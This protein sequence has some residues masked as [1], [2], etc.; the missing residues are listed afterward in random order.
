MA[1]SNRTTV[2]NLVNHH[3]VTPL[4]DDKTKKWLAQW[5]SDNGY[6]RAYGSNPNNWS[7]LIN[8]FTGKRSYAQAHLVGQRV[9]SRT[10][11]ASAAE[12]KAGYRLIPIVKDIWGQI[13]WGAGN[14]TINKGAIN[15]EHCGDYRNYT[16]R[17]KDCEVIADFWR[18]Q[19]KKLKGNTRVWGHKE[20]SQT[21]TACPARI[22]EK[23][24]L[25]V[26]Y[27]NNPPKEEDEMISAH[28]LNVL[29]RLYKGGSP[30]AAQKKLYVGKVSFDRMSQ[31]IQKGTHYKSIVAKAKAGK[32]DPSVHLPSAIRNVYKPPVAQPPKSTE[33]KPGI[34]EVK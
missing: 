13:V 1:D 18:P 20:V 2:K 4:W 29:F 17:S 11:D 15:I 10:P 27:V 3:A 31:V 26:K 34:Y 19:D 28:G 14:W 32:L 33:L 23:R 21:G 9:T 24:D 6:A 5:F 12:K 30:T 25:I 22:M 7:G 16:L 8:P